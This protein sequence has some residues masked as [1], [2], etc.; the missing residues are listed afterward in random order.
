[1]GDKK[2]AAEAFRKYSFCHE[3]INEYWG[4]AN[5]LENAAILDLEIAVQ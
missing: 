4:A 3:K 5:G 1:M 2:K